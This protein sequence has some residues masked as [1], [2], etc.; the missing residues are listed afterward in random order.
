[1]IHP[2]IQKLALHDAYIRMVLDVAKSRKLSYVETLEI[3]VIEQ[4]SDR[5]RLVQ[6]GVKILE[7]SPAPPIYL[8]PEETELPA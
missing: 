7:R 5:A 1:M 2:K 8:N 6:L 4:A 3:L